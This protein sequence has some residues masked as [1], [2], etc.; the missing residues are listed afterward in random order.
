MK[1]N[2]FSAAIFIFIIAIIFNY[3]STDKKSTTALNIATNQN[4]YLPIN[5]VIEDSNIQKTIKNNSAITL[6]SSNTNINASLIIKPIP[7][8]K[9]D[10]NNNFQ[11]NNSEI[12][13]DRVLFNGIDFSKF[14]N[15]KIIDVID[16]NIYLPSNLLPIYGPSSEIFSTVK[17]GTSD[18][19]D[20]YF[21]GGRKLLE[22]IKD[23]GVENIKNIVAF[24]QD[25]ITIQ[26]QY[27]R[28]QIQFQLSV[29][30]DGQ[31]L[32][33]I[34]LLGN[35]LPACAEQDTREISITANVGSITAQ[36]C[37]QGFKE[38]DELDLIEIK[39]PN[40]YGCIT[41]YRDSTVNLGDPR[42]K[43][44]WVNKN[45]IISIDC[46]PAIM[47]SAAE[48]VRFP[49]LKKLVV[50]SDFPNFELINNLTDLKYLSIYN[51]K[52]TARTFDLHHIKNLENL[53]FFSAY[54][55]NL[56]STNYMSGLNKLKSVIISKVKVDN[57]EFVKF[58]TNVTYFDITNNELDIF[59]DIGFGDKVET[60][61]ANSNNLD[62]INGFENF[63]NLKELSLRNNNIYNV[64]N[65]DFDNSNYTKIELF[66]NPITC[67]QEAMNKHSF[68][69][70]K[71]ND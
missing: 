67:N 25:D 37:K 24:T 18:Q 58:L 23:E 51:Y 17:I 45:D 38:L 59:P 50:S 15:F 33:S 36:S 35:Q 64:D 2:L 65:L 52:P 19:G 44:G 8:A 57:Y 9:T 26:T 66:A 21:N 31:S 20:V 22:L 46:T 53:E 12:K 5:K 11:I 63:T 55:L 40:F 29:V 70:V 48:I 49:N 71:C 10:L 42:I 1:I 7:S 34:T 62:N 47:Q 61:H 69:K 28:S 14:T 30:V 3:L 43:K 13:D 68:M 41:N 4:F 39:D 6:D 16:K 27:E 54:N 60:I 32:S 56:K